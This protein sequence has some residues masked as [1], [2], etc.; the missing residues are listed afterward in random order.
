MPMAADSGAS[1]AILSRQSLQREGRLMAQSVCR[2]VTVVELE[3]RGFET[4]LEKH[5]GSAEVYHYLQVLDA[6]ALQRPREVVA[7]GDEV[8]RRWLPILLLWDWHP[9]QPK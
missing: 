7:V 1:A 5:R 6:V 2:S 4:R 8:A 9:F 3:D